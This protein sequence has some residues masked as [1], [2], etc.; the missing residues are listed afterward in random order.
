MSQAA[1]NSQQKLYLVL[2]RAILIK[3]WD[4]LLFTGLKAQYKYI[5]L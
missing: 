4:K 3:D 2:L 1:E 5:K